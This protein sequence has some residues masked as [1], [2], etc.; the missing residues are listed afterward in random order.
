MGQSVSPAIE[1]AH[2]RRLNSKASLAVRR[3]K[4]ARGPATQQVAVQIAQNIN[5]IWRIDFV[6]DRL[7]NARRFTCQ[8]VADD[9]SHEYIDIA[10]DW[11]M[12]A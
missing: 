1:I 3:R 12:H 11:A 2:A 8:T 9:F 10:V 6:S 7:S 5:G 4:K